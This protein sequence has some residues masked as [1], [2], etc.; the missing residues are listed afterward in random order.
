MTKT[1]TVVPDICRSSVCDLLH[2]TFLNHTLKGKSIELL[3]VLG[4]GLFIQHTRSYS[5]YLGDSIPL[6]IV[7]ERDLSWRGESEF[8]RLRQQRYS[9]R[10]SCT[11]QGNKVFGNVYQKSLT[12]ICACLINRCIQNK[13][14][15]KQM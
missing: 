11:S 14:V 7:L 12:L 8:M 13:T 6:L 1:F 10:G 3:Y 2:V 5:L 15:C 4:L 9:N